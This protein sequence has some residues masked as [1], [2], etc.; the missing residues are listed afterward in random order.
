MRKQIATNLIVGLAILA[1]GP[2][3]AGEMRGMKGMDMDA[4]AGHA[5]V[6]H[7]TRGVVKKLE[8]E[9]A[10]VTL[11]HEPVASLN[12]PSMTMGFAVRDKALL[13]G[14][15]EGETVEV[16]FVRDGK[17]YVITAVK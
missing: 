9:S 2:A 10:K 5:D 3:I 14:F 7:V 4:P 12:W 13:G 17:D 6:T 16:E 8:V 1:A 11:K 15:V